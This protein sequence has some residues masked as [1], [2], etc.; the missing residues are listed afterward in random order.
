MYSYTQVFLLLYIQ[1]NLQ[2]SHDLHWHYTTAV[3]PPL[4]CGHSELRHAREQI[5][6]TKK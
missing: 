4:Q 3:Y 2:H 1:V 5:A 6:A